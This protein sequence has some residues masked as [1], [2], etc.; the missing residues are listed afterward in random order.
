MPAVTRRATSVCPRTRFLISFSSRNWV[1]PR[2]AMNWLLSATIRAVAMG[3]PA[4]W[5]MPRPTY[6]APTRTMLWLK[7]VTCMAALTT[8]NPRPEALM[9]CRSHDSA[10]S[11][12]TCCLRSPAALSFAQSRSCFRNSG[13]RVSRTALANSVSR[14]RRFVPIS[15][16]CHARSWMTSLTPL[17]AAS[18]VYRSGRSTTSLARAFTNDRRVVAA[19]YAPSIAR[20]ASA[21]SSMVATRSLATGSYLMG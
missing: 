16:S 2:S 3:A 9:P 13:P 19:V 20:L 5:A 11:P 14:S 8:L 7:P 6:L 21:T 4:N 15:H 17:K 10:P 18:S 12:A 1:R